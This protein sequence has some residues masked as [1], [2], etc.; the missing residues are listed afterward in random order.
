MK[1]S[2]CFSKGEPTDYLKD[3]RVLINEVIVRYNREREPDES[4]MTSICTALQI[5]EQQNSAVHYAL[6]GMVFMN[7]GD[8]DSAIKTLMKALD[9]DSSIVVSHA[10]LGIVYLRLAIFDMFDRGLCEINVVDRHS[11]SEKALSGYLGLLIQELLASG[12]PK[13][14]IQAL[15][16]RGYHEEDRLAGLASVMLNTLDKKGRFYPDWKTDL[17]KVIND[18]GRPKRLAVPT[19]TLDE[20]ARRILMLASKELRMAGEGTV[21]LP[22]GWTV[23]R[24]DYI[25][26]AMKAVEMLL[27]E[28]QQEISVRDIRSTVVQVYGKGLVEIA[29]GS[30]EGIG[31]GMV[32]NVK[33]GRQEICKIR[34]TNVE[35]AKA[36]GTTFGDIQQNPKVGDAVTGRLIK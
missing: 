28:T 8:F 11:I 21:V 14:Y 26:A 30:A 6:A 7:S 18:L 27:G 15:T 29:A 25:K 5:A 31:I 34:I 19:F 4:L 32:F 9:T 13:A 1:D 2:S 23:I 36:M 24:E 10:I 17:N 20:C 33:R 12:R 35:T 16:D 22:S 3:D